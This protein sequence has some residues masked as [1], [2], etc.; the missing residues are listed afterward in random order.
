MT[1]D[2][3]VSPLNMRAINSLVEVLRLYATARRMRSAVTSGN[4]IESFS[5]RDTVAPETAASLATSRTVARFEFLNS[6]IFVQSK[7]TTKKRIL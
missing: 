7:R 1:F 4:L 5:Q 6:V 2:D 3:C